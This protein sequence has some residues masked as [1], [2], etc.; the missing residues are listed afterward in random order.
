MANPRT[1]IPGTTFFRVNYF[2]DDLLIPAVQTLIFDSKYSD[3]SGDDLWVFR[4]PG[5]DDEGEQG[6]VIRVGFGESDLY[7]LLN[8]AE[9]TGVIG[10]LQQVIDASAPQGGISPQATFAPDLVSIEQN[11]RDWGKQQK[12][13]LH[14][15]ARYTDDGLFVQMKDGQPRLV[16]FSHPLRKQE[17][18]LR[19]NALLSKWSL[20]PEEDYLADKGRTRVLSARLP[21]DVGV[22]AKICAEMFTVVYQSAGD[23]EL[24][25]EVTD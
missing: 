12:R 11:I 18:N 2:D 9:L 15:S 25:F 13:S 7:Q 5:Q 17:E 1:L 23:T 3:D 16:L 24:Q 21:S 20:S 22:I 8:Y 10:E 4:E 19:L 6:E 14:I